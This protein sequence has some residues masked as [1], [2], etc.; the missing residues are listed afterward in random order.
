MALRALE[1][2]LYSDLGIG[3]KSCQRKEQT[4]Y[5]FKLPPLEVVPQFGKVG[6]EQKAD[7][8]RYGQ[9]RV[10]DCRGQEGAGHAQLPPPP[11]LLRPPPP[12]P[13]PYPGFLLVPSSSSGGGGDLNGDLALSAAEI[14]GEAGQPGAEGLLL[15]LQVGDE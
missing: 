6:V 15:A 13:L 12:P 5:F 14:G 1:T 4:F 10:R 7:A 11:P 2:A 3:T 9:D 8:A